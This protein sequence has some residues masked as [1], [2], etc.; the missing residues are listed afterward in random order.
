MYWIAVQ[1]FCSLQYCTALTNNEGW[2]NMARD[3]FL[4][5]EEIYASKKKRK[6]FSVI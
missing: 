6:H 3:P 2:E 5:T 1:S 4:E